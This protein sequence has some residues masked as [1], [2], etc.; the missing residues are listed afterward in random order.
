MNEEA[1]RKWLDTNSN[2]A[3]KI[4]RDYSLRGAYVASDPNLLT[5]DD[6]GGTNSP[7][8]ST[9]MSSLSFSMAKTINASLNLSD[10]VSSVLSTAVELIKA[11]RCSLFLV[12]HAAGELYSTVWDV[13]PKNQ[14]LSR[15]GSG[16]PSGTLSR[17]SSGADSDVKP[18][19]GFT[20]FK[21]F[22]IPIGSGVAGWVAQTGLAANIEDAY[23]DKRFNQEA[24]KKSGYRTRTMLCMPI[25][26]K[27]VEGL[28]ESDLSCPRVKT[29]HGVPVHPDLIGIA[30]LINKL[31]SDDDF[32]P[33]P[34]FTQEDE[35][36]FGD[37]LL[38]C[39]IAIN[40]SLLFENAQKAEKAANK[41]AAHNAKL[42][43]KANVEAKKSKA[44]LAVA[45]SLYGETNVN[46]LSQKVITHA[47]DLTNAELASLWLL[48][49][50]KQELYSSVFN[51][52]TQEKRLAVPAGK[53][54]VGYVAQTGEIVNLEDAYADPRFNK[55]IDIQ[56]NYRT[57]SI[58]CVPIHGPS[59][60]CLGVANLINKQFKTPDG[61]IMHIPFDTN[62]EHILTA[63]SVFC[64]LSLAKT[65]LLEQISRQQRMLTVAME[66][67]SFHATTHPSDFER[68]IKSAPR[69]TVPYEQLRSS[70]FD[71]H[72][73]GNEDDR[74]VV[75]VRQMFLDM[76]YVEKFRIPI[77]KWD[78]YMLTVRKNYRPGKRS[79]AY[80]NF[81]HAVS[82]AHMVYYL[83]KS[84]ALAG[85]TDDVEQFSMFVAALNHDIDHRGTNNQFQKNAQTALAAFYSTS[86]MERHHFNHAMT[87]LSAP[88]HNILEAMDE[89]NYAR[90]LK[91]FENA[92]LATDLAV[93][94]ANKGKIAKIVEGGGVDREN[95]EHRDLVLLTLLLGSGVHQLRGLVMTCSDL[96]AMTKPFHCAKRTAD[97]V[98]EEFFIQGEE[99][100]RLNLP[101]SA[102]LMDRS[103]SVEI[104]RMQMDFM[105]FI[106]KPAFDALGGM[107]DGPVKKLNEAVNY[108]L[109]KWKELKESGQPYV[110]HTDGH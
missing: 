85:Y 74:L 103:K 106:V 23:A 16:S 21:E 22:R 8:R 58:L 65:I 95:G 73:Y 61:K 52:G 59:K 99:E 70:E 43:E 81:T 10:R 26:S 78:Q 48:D 76:G 108:N 72:D 7:R 90:C 75:I 45:E 5:D 89:Q 19:G 64:G 17:S 37:F 97:H 56:T 49:E 11:D 6:D 33:F 40:N 47:R 14:S 86:T 105:G 102:E 28:H 87:I 51:T 30:T 20:P 54:V 104:P 27:P 15:S 31:P 77:E 3:R 25:F 93:Y 35:R 44:L 101:Y 88:G 18:A 2:A 68:F 110:M 36:V 57:R 60:K 84:G 98:Y 1:V 79:V 53:G 38:M 34:T 67:M 13:M 32:N 107:I 91:Y 41:L 69:E 39:G 55:D 29:E 50:D 24:D 92:I 12:D 62:D 9:S 94:F 96:S 71:P 82:V 63:F 46:E 80:H 109:G 4:A 100:R 42:F 83:V 66:L